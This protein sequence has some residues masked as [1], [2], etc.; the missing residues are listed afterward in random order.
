[1]NSVLQARGYATI[2]VTPRTCIAVENT[3]KKKKKKKKKKTVRDKS[4][5]IFN[6]ILSYPY[7]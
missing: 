1:M 7:L 6:T 4:V 2:Y 5:I 3:C